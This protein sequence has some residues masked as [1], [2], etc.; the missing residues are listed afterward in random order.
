MLRRRQ[1]LRTGPELDDRELRRTLAEIRPSSQLHGL[2]ADNT[3]P[4]W[5]SV[6]GL[7][8]ATGRDWDRRTHRISVLART[9]PPA[10]AD[11]WAAARPEDPDAAVVRAYV[12]TTRA[13][14]GVG[15]GQAEEAC[16]RAA[17]A[18][19]PD[20]TPWLSL[21]SL[22]RSRRVPLAR[23]LPVWNEIVRRDPW[24][25]LAHHELLRYLSPR[26]RGSLVEMIAFARRGANAPHGSPLALLPLAAR[27]E[28]FGHRLRPGSLDALGAGTHWYEPGVT[29]EID[30]AMSRWFHADAPPHAHAMADLNILAFALTRAKR[31]SEAAQAFRRIGRYMTPYPWDLTE[32]PVGTFLYWS[33]GPTHR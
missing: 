2:G 23:A 19:P 24:N 29:A 12:L 7:L 3:A 22:L 1:Q 18:Y 13:K 28:H 30:S 11:R 8:R 33:A 9:L 14:D 31:H 10:V 26:E 17:E 32:D 4:L 20:P 5:K 16:V 21:L 6:A 15:A 25:R 27:T